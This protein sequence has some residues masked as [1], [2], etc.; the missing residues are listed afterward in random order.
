MDEGAELDS[1]SLDKDANQITLCSASYFL[2]C[3][4]RA[5][6][7]FQLTGQLDLPT[8]FVSQTAW[9]LSALAYQ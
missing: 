7:F 8:S 5:I 6:A 4:V 3:R 9:S 2:R 1:V